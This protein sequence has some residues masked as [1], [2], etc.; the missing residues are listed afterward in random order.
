MSR[1]SQHHSCV[2]PCICLSGFA[3]G[4]PGTASSV[5]RQLCSVLGLSK[6]SYWAW[7]VTHLPGALH[8]W[9]WTGQQGLERKQRAGKQPQPAPLARG[10]D[11]LSQEVYCPLIWGLCWLLCF[12]GT[13]DVSCCSGGHRISRSSQKRSRVKGGPRPQT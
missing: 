3:K 6:G 2:V 10:R 1:A 5:S 9:A 13:A 4:R 12:F 8:K 7:A 11:L